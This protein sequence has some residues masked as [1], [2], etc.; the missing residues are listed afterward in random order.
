MELPLTLQMEID[1]SVMAHK[2]ELAEGFA[3]LRERVLPPEAESDAAFWRRLAA[4][5]TRKTMELALTSFDM[6]G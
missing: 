4:L 3:K 6:R 1:L 2:R 5:N